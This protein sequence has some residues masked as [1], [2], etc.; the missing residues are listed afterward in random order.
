MGLVERATA[1]A[2]ARVVAKM[3][4]DASGLLSACSPREGGRRGGGVRWALA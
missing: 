4:L 1:T 3:G 2:R